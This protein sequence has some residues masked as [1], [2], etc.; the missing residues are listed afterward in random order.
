MT[1]Y[2]RSDDHYGKSTCTT[3]SCA[4]NWPAFKGDGSRV[5]AGAGV[6]GV[7]GTTTWSNGTVQVTYNGQPLYYYKKDVTVGDALGQRRGGVWFIVLVGDPSAC[8]A[9]GTPGGATAPPRFPAPA[10]RA[11]KN[12][13]GE[14]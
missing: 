10:V 13:N 12:S 6:Y 5:R 2:T 14:Y 4:S 9:P 3:G 8:Q 7:F 1:L 11:S